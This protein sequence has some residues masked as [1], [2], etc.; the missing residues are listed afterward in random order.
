MTDK[1]PHISINR[2]RE[3]RS[4]RRG[5]RWEPFPAVATRLRLDIA[6]V[7]VTSEWRFYFFFK[8]ND[9]IRIVLGSPRES[10]S[11][12]RHHGVFSP[13]YKDGQDLLFFLKKI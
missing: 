8:K 1:H 7:A 6:T 2:G 4:L 9:L 11:E 12:S 10:V 13:D 3:N 5:A